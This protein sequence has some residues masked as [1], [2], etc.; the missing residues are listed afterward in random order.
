MGKSKEDL[1]TEILAKDM[2]ISSVRLKE[3]NLQSNHW[4][5]LMASL[6]KLDESEIAIDENSKNYRKH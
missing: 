2:G 3:A 4:K 1:V 6:G 5:K